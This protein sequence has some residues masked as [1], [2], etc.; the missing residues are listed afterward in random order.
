[1]GMPDA[2]LLL[3]EKGADANATDDMGRSALHWL[4][5]TPEELD[6]SAKTIFTAQIERSPS[7][8]H[9]RDREGFRPLHL[10]VQHSHIW[11]ADTL[12]NLGEDQK[13]ADPDGNTSLHFVTTQLW[14]EKTKRLK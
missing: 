9:L 4:C 11:A 14:G 12:I 13:E 2:A 10:A 3:L 5:T 7:R 8:V 6:D 1:T